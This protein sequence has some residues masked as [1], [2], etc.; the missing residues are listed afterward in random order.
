MAFELYHNDMST[1]AMKVR[2]VLAEKGL[3][4]EGHHM[5][6]RAGDTRTKEYI[7]NLNP[8]GVVPTLVDDGVII[9]E[10][11]V[12]MEYLDDAYPEP[13]LRAADPRERARMRLWTKQL[14]EGVHAA[15]GTISVCIAFRY[16]MTGDRNEAEVNSFIDKIPDPVRRERS[17][18]AILRGVGSSYFAPAILRFEK[19]WNDIERAL[20]NQAWLAGGTYSLADAAYTPYIT[21]FDHLQLLGIL[22]T[23][24]RLADWYERI[25]ARPSYDEA[26]RKWF[27]PKYLPLMEEK[28]NEARQQVQ[29]IIAKAT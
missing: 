3:N 23:R 24:P 13:P 10:S 18:N 26:L 11:T 20:G 12:I 4:W 16:Q 14:D 17:R 7:E 22:E 5:D 2:L 21:R 28:G 19:L 9:Y 25:K 1:C 8:G 15:T 27:N 6:L 29:E